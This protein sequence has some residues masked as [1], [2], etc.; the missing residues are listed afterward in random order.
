[1]ERERIVQVFFFAFLALMAYEL[2]EVL[3]PF[4]TPIAWAILLAFMA[5]PAVALLDRLIKRRTVSALVLTIAVALLVI[6]PAAWLSGRLVVEAQHLYTDVSEMTVNG[7]VL[8]AGQWITATR[9][10]AALDAMLERHGISLEDEVGSFAAQGAKLLSGYVVAHGEAVASNLASIVFHFVIMLLTL[11]Y[12]LRDGESYYEGVRALT[13]LHEEDKAAV[14]ETLRITLSSVMR[15]LLLTALL[16]GVSIGI[17]YLVCGVPYWAF[18]GILSAA[19][20]LLPIGGTAIVWVPAAIYLAVEVGW[21]VAA[22]LVAWALV[23]L[24]IV[25][26]FIKPMA[27]KHGTGLPTLALFFGLAGGIEAYGAL[28]IFAGPAVIAVFASLLLVYRRTYF[29]ETLEPPRVPV[30]SRRQ[31]R[32]KRKGRQ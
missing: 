23:T 14:F 9:P 17:A 3:Y 4:L 29:S 30:E 16:D 22:I 28:G 12:M 15:G 8:K 1:M 32:W 6:L 20:G 10:G 25:D 13:P 7:S 18:L 5:H 31:R 24:I 21:G 19:C 27:M 2:Y 11:F 26:N